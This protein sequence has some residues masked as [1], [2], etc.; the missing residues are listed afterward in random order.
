[1]VK[2]SEKPKKEKKAQAEVDTPVKK[3]K[4]DKKEK[5]EKKVENGVQN[6]KPDAAPAVELVIAEPQTEEKKKNKKRKSE[7]AAVA[8]LEAPSP[9]TE[10]KKKKKKKGML[11]EAAAPPVAE[12]V[13]IVKDVD[14]EDAAELDVEMVPKEVVHKQ[15]PFL[16]AIADPLADEKL[17]KKLLK[18]AKK[19]SKRKQ[20]KR[21]VKEVVKAIRKKFKG[22]C[23]IAGDISPIDVITHIPVLCE[24]NDIPYIYVPSKEALGAAGLTK[25]PTSCMLLL[26]KPLKGLS[27]DDADAKDFE[28]AYESARTKIATVEPLY[29]RL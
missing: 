2:S 5:K 27:A 14:E 25:R 6:G 13:A 22:I 10:K 12:A 16:S 17:T 28:E 23:L 8:A 15:G 24:E 1:M 18:L 20:T 9:V 29:M 11:E 21:G 7:D 4:K 3:I 19:A 26:P